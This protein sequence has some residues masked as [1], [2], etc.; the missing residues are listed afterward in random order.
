METGRAQRQ[1]GNTLA[2]GRENAW[3]KARLPREITGNTLEEIGSV[4]CNCLD[5]LKK[6][7]AKRNHDVIA[8][9]PEIVFPARPTNVLVSVSPAYEISASQ[10]GMPL[11]YTSVCAWQ[12][13]ETLRAFQEKQLLQRLQNL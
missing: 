13:V 6:E 5:G 7:K 4:A 2:N 3:R 9:L 1:A 10:G 11:A 12:T 8:F